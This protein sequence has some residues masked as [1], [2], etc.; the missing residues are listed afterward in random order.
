[1]PLTSGK[2]IG[3]DPRSMVYRF[4]MFDGNRCVDCDISNAA[5][6]AL[7]EMWADPRLT[8]EA[9]FRSHRKLIEG[10]ASDQYRGDLGPVRIFAK[11]LPSMRVRDGRSTKRPPSRRLSGS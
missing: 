6:S 10:V 3:Y 2:P 4:T 5:L 11:H 1:M 8:H 9:V 7:G